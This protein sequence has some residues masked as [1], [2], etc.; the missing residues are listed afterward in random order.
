MK[1]AADNENVEADR[2]T[3]ERLAILG[4]LKAEVTIHQSMEVV[5]VSP[6]GL[7]VVTP[8]PFQID[9]LHDIR[10]SLG[11]HTL[12]VKGRI[13]HCQIADVDQESVRYR[14]GIECTEIP[15]HVRTAMVEFV[16]A[17][18]NERRGSPSARTLTSD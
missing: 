16:E 13:T 9:S 8:F 5:E 10:L 2:R 11:L 12:V 4:D 7:Q 18:K 14:S 6:A 1:P 17:V 3:Q 15:D